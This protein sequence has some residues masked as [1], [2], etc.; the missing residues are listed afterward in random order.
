M[1]LEIRKSLANKYFIIICIFG[2]VISLLHSYIIIS[3]YKGISQALEVY[4]S[5][6]QNPYSP[7]TNTFTLWIGWD[8]KSK[9]S[10]LLF[11]IFPLLSVTPYCWSYSSEYRKGI[12]NNSII[13][14]GVSHYHLAKY[15]AVFVSSGLIMAIPLLINFLA[16]LLFVPPISPDSVY[17]I[18]YGVFSNSFMAD[19]FYMHPFIYVLTFIILNFIYCGLFGCL[20]YAISTI[21]P[22]R[23]ISVLAPVFTI[24]AI[25]YTKN[26]VIEQNAIERKNFSPKAFLCPAKSLDT[27]NVIVIVEIIA[28]FIITFFIPILRFKVI[29]RRRI[30][31]EN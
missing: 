14:N 16:I 26:S 20:G 1:L 23:I 24:L 6:G 21:I 19:T 18:Y 17:D 30:K 31:N 22:S 10:K 8:Y 25:D 28:L 12:T 3:D 13:K 9:Y 2:I 7:I 4:S 11:N 27:N 29:V 15:T 5:K